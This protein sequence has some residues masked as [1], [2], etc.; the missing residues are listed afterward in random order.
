MRVAAAEMNGV[1][2]GLECL[3][4]EGRREAQ[5]VGAGVP[6]DVHV[7]TRLATD[8][9]G[10]G[11]GVGARR[12]CMF[13]RRI[14]LGRFKL[15]K[16]NESGCG[17]GCASHVVRETPGPDAMFTRSVLFVSRRGQ[18]EVKIS[19]RRPDDA[20]LIFRMKSILWNASSRG[21]LVSSHPLPSVIQT[22][23]CPS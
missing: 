4:V 20:I 19:S 16:E 17:S 1:R 14:S 7:A 23:V 10:A 3:P 8:G 9:L 21:A 22:K 18:L 2:P 13:R 12:W 15:E 5:G 11:V 6:K